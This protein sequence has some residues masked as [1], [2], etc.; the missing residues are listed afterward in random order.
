MPKQTRAETDLYI[1][2][3]KLNI[4]RLVHSNQYKEAFELLVQSGNVLEWSD[5]RAVL[6]YLDTVRLSSHNR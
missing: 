5:Y 2:K 4:N 3:L 6:Q 1:G